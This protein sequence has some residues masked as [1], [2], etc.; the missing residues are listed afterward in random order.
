M[1]TIGERPDPA[2]CSPLAF[3]MV[4]TDREPETNYGK[5]CRCVFRV[6]RWY[7]YPCSMSS[8]INRKTSLH[9]TCFTC[10]FR[11]F[12]STLVELA[13]SFL[14]TRMS[15]SCTRLVSAS[16]CLFSVQSLHVTVSVFPLI[17]LH[18]W[19]FRGR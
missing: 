12:F 2:A 10:F 19:I 17:L 3:S 16:G 4:L 5:P 9:F 6:Y 13:L 18:R 15:T 8:Q 7:C 14:I 1:E 11:F